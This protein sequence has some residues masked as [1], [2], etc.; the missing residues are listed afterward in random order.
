MGRRTNVRGII[1]KESTI[2]PKPFRI[3][4]L[5]RPSTYDPAVAA[6]VPRH[7]PP[8]SELQECSFATWPKFVKP[9]VYIVYDV[10]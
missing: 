5:C 9:Q 1:E 2:A 7:Q 4:H 10:L 3:V 8:N 6:F